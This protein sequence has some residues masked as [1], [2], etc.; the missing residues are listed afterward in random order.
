MTGTT[1]FKHKIFSAAF[2]LIFGFTIAVG[3]ETATSQQ[4]GLAFLRITMDAHGAAR[5]GALT[6]SGTGLSAIQWNPAGLVLESGN[7]VMI[8]H[9]RGLEDTDSELFSLLW[10]RKEN[11]AFALSIFSNNIDNIE[12]RTK[13]T[14]SP[15]GIISAHDFYA[16]LT[17]STVYAD[18]FQIGV[19]MR[20]L[21]QKIYH[22]D[23]SGFSGD[24]G[25][26]YAPAGRPYAFG[27]VLKNMGD[28]AA[29]RDENPTMPALFRMGSSYTLNFQSADM[30][31]VELA[32]EYETIF[33]GDD[34]LHFGLDYRYNRLYHV[35]LGYISGYE[36][37]RMSAGAGISK[38][39]YTL[40]YAYLPEIT[41]FYNQ[42]LLSFILGF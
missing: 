28:M 1:M 33:D 29:L 30:H 14:A 27:A 25:V 41:S 19:T 36:S 11:Q 21:Y 35:R 5:G 39:R 31:S 17:Y 9:A 4:P 26:R 16:G 10:K 42:H 40:D 12:F 15:E 32:A 34:Y 2:L 37:G 23:A 22:S 3:P 24:L 6:A 38:G 20:Y 7:Q 18:N 13:P 8:S